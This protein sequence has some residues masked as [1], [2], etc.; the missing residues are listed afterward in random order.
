MISSTTGKKLIIT[1]GGGSHEK[2]MTLKMEGLPEGYIIRGQRIHDILERR[3]PGNSPLS[4]SRKEA[5]LPLLKYVD[6]YVPID[7]NTDFAIPHSGQLEFVIKNENFKVKDYNLKLPRPGHAD[8]PA[9]IKYGDSVN[10]SG[11]GPF[12]GRMTAMLT[13]AGAVAAEILTYHNIY[14]GSS[15]LSIGKCQGTPINPLAPVDAGLT[16]EME[17]E[18]LK[19]KENGDSV[20][21]VIEGFA[22]GIPVGIGGPLFHG[23]ESNL[24]NLLFGIPAIKGVEFGKGFRAAR[25]NGSDNNDDILAFNNEK[26]I[27]ET[28]NCGGILGGISTGMPLTLRVAIKPT[29]SIEKPQKTVNVISGQPEILSIH[30]RHDPCIIPRARVVVE[31]TMAVGILDMMLKSDEIEPF[32]SI[33]EERKKFAKS[34]GNEHLYISGNA[35]PNAGHHHKSNFMGAGIANAHNGVVHDN[36]LPDTIMDF[37][38]E[39]CVKGLDEMRQEIDKIDQQIVRLLNQRMTVAKQVAEYKKENNI[40]VHDGGRESKILAKVGEDYQDIYREIF[41]VSKNLQKKITDD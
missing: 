7:S 24:A 26:I 23:M 38:Q 6:S 17:A 33:N 19:A 40:A 25:M 35:H 3:A 22:T 2:A 20:G 14:I 28:N 31:A 34:E 5:D 18:I 39:D 11:G 12:S 41:K 13:L 15:V 10:M 8:L 1:I 4:T 30:G 16:A 21:G 29:P 32:E 9:F 36:S 27:T 37:H